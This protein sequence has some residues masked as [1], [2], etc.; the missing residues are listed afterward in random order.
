MED[1]QPPAESSNII[2]SMWNGIVEFIDGTKMPE[3]IEK[4]DMALF[5]NPWFAVPFFCLIAYQLYKQ[6][7]RDLII[8]GLIFAIWYASGTTYMKTLTVG[9][10]LQV[11]KVLPVL[12]GGAAA[13]GLI[14]YLLFGRSD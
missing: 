11:S 2:I 14:I 5:S 12:F 6:S 9:G 8:E 13:I 4:V 1:V 10:E 3:Q 7:F